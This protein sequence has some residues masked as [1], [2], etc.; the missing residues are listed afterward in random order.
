MTA[1]KLLHG[2]GQLLRGAIDLG[3]MALA[4]G[5]A[6]AALPGRWTPLGAIAVAVVFG[7]V[8]IWLH[9]AGHYVGARVMGMRVLRVNATLVD[10]IPQRRGLRARWRGVRGLGGFVYAL[11]VPD[12][13]MRPAYLAHIAGG[14]GANLLV[15]LLCMLTVWLFRETQGIGLLLAFGVINAALGV[16]NLVPRA[17]A[18]HND[19]YLLL[20]WIRG[21]DEQGPA[22]LPTRLASLSVSGVQADALPEAE[23]AEMER[24]P[25]P[26][27][28]HALWYRIKAAQ[29]RGEWEAAP[30]LK[31][32][33]ETQLALLDPAMRTALHDFI[34]L[35]RVE[36]AFSEAMRV[37][38]D[39]PLRDVAIGRDIAWFAPPLVP[40]LDALYAASSGDAAVCLRALEQARRYAENEIEASV[41]TSEARIAT[42]LLERF[43]VTSSSMA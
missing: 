11:P 6:A 36:I 40:R 29:H 39:A 42:A 41:A 19:G 14:P 4:I 23:L 22:L 37:R 27:P 15:A 21:V 17:N 43:G 7:I 1:T 30:A 20:S 5:F 16:S 31:E 38:S 25:S 2:L 34:E 35:L 13:P 26:L 10:M 3:G 24:Q 8:A 12:R 18:I 9:E 28:L 32:A 33:L